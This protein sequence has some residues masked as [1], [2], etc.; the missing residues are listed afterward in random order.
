MTYGDF[1]TIEDTKCQLCVLNL[2]KSLPKETHAYNIIIKTIL[3]LRVWG[4]K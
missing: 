4:L 2:L 1:F 3:S